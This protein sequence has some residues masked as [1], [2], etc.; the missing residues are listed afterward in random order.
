MYTIIHKNFK[1]RLREQLFKMN[2]VNDGGPRHGAV[3]SELTFYFET[4]KKL[5]VL[6]ENDISDKSM[7]DIWVK[8]I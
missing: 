4:M 1:D 5:K 6:K 3:T 2:I 8:K 7:D